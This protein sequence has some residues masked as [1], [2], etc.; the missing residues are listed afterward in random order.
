VTKARGIHPK[1][2]DMN[3]FLAATLQT[4]DGQKLMGVADSSLKILRTDFAALSAKDL[5]NWTK[6][7]FSEVKKLYGADV[8]QKSSDF[9]DALASW[10]AAPGDIAKIGAVERAF[11]TL[12]SALERSP[13]NPKVYDME[14]TFLKVTEFRNSCYAAMATAALAADQSERGISES[15]PDT[16]AHARLASIGDSLTDRF[17]EMPENGKIGRNDSASE[18]WQA[19]MS[20]IAAQGSAEKARI[21]ACLQGLENPKLKP[22][23]R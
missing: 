8:T 6:R 4:S 15:L 19:Q 14:T 21:L 23:D 11:Q 9:G 2:V 12:A 7:I 20:N 13:Q 10:A 22:A 3:G 1:A 16:V 18:Y 17:G 5:S